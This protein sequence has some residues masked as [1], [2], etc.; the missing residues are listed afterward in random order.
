M[1][2]PLDRLYENY[3][4]SEMHCD[5]GIYLHTVAPTNGA[6]D[7]LLEAVNSYAKTCLLLSLHVTE[8]EI[9]FVVLFRD[10]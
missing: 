3:F 1:L 10:G 9:S 8:E 7:T 5:D 6:M 2:E 4:L